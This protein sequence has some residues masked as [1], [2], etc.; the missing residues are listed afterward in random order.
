LCAVVLAIAAA[1]V[2]PVASA[3]GPVLIALDLCSLHPETNTAD[4]SA[5]TALFFDIQPLKPEGRLC[6]DDFQNPQFLLSSRIERPP[7]A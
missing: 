3:D 4:M 6:A 2:A 5:V 1:H 7:R